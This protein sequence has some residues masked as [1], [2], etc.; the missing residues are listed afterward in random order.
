MDNTDYIREQTL[1]EFIQTNFKKVMILQGEGGTGK[2]FVAKILNQPN[3]I[4][5]ASTW[6]AGSL[7]GS[8]TYYRASRLPKDFE[9]YPPKVVTKSHKVMIIDEASMLSYERLQWMMKKWPNRRFFLIGDWMQLPPVS[10]NSNRACT[11]IP[12]ENYPIIQLTKQWRALDPNLVELLIAVREANT[13]KAEKILK[14]LIIKESDVDKFPIRVILSQ[15]NVTRNKWKN[16]VSAGTK[17]GATV[18]GYHKVWMDRDG[19]Y[20]DPGDFIAQGEEIMDNYFKVPEK[21]LWLNN[22]FLTW[23]NFSNG[24][25]TMRRR[26]GSEFKVW[27]PNNCYFFHDAGSLTI[28]KIQGVTLTEPIIISGD[29]DS[30]R[31][32]YVALS[33]ARTLDQLHLLN[34]PNMKDWKP[35]PILDTFDTG[36]DDE[37][38]SKDDLFEEISMGAKNEFLDTIYSVQEV[39][40]SPHK[41]ESRSLG[42]EITKIKYFGGSGIIPYSKHFDRLNREGARFQPASPT[43]GTVFDPVNGEHQT[44]NPLKKHATN[45]N[46]QNIDQFI[47]FAYEWD[48]ISIEEQEA[49]VEEWRPYIWKVIHSGSKSLHVWLTLHEPIHLQL[50]HAGLP[51]SAWKSPEVCE[52]AWRIINNYIIKLFKRKPCSSATSPVQ[53]LRGHSQIRLDGKEQK[54]LFEQKKAIKLPTVWINWLID[55]LREEMKAPGTI[56]EMKAK[57]VK[58][59]PTHNNNKEPPIPDDFNS[60]EGARRIHWSICMN[61]TNEQIISDFGL[62]NANGKRR[63]KTSMINFIEKLRKSH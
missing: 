55:E 19:N 62:T 63:N 35:Y 14:K 12:I 32:W 17:V 9:L 8:P 6:V 24:Y 37:N 54:I 49:I 47:N 38:W 44:K 4:K 10:D 46:I 22:E 39:K 60:K 42:S 45:H 30:Q 43:H 18:I 26:D 53:L 59:E 52:R 20:G 13:L 11:P 29:S 27:W 1:A 23:V 36:S 48:D 41:I 34:L 56:S 5:G 3:T 40:K 58:S 2:S 57:Q 7:I 51:E 50:K 28:Y 25:A 61:Y 33:R 21:R 15:K 16:S 31:E